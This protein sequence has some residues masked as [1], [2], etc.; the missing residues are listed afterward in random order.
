M[1][2]WLAIKFE[3]AILQE[4]D[5]DYSLLIGMLG[6]YTSNDFLE[7]TTFEIVNSPTILLN[8]ALFVLNC[9]IAKNSF[10]RFWCIDLFKIQTHIIMKNKKTRYHFVLDKSGSMNSCRESTIQ[11]F[12]SQLETIKQLQKEF[13]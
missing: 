8:I 4:I 1:I 6:G 9:K 3:C 7:I 11:G 5:L 13:P 10:W 12:N 2:G